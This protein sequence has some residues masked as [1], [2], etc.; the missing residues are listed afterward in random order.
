M[1][2]FTLTETDTVT[3]INGFQTHFISIGLGPCQC[4]HIL[5]SNYLHD[6]SDDIELAETQ[7]IYFV[8]VCH[9]YFLHS[10]SKYK[11]LKCYV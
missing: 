1:E 2:V 7:T 11:V 10:L 8:A 3:D 6:V 9:K 4:E 5:T